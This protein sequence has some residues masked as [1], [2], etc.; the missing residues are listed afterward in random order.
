MKIVIKN[1]FIGLS[2]WSIKSACIGNFG[3]FGG[4]GK[5]FSWNGWKISIGTIKE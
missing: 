1:K 2:K 3:G 4:Y 5:Y